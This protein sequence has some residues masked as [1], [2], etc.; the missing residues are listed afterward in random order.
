MLRT[1]VLEVVLRNTTENRFGSK[2][3]D[4]TLLIIYKAFIQ[5]SENISCQADD[6][7]AVFGRQKRGNNF[8]MWLQGCV[9][10]RYSLHGRSIRPADRL[11]DQKRHKI[12]FLKWCH[13]L[14][15]LWQ[16]TNQGKLLH[17]IHVF[18]LFSTSTLYNR[19][20]LLLEADLNVLL[21]MLMGTAQSYVYYTKET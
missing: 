17:I 3:T 1:N 18:L 21:R 9:A 12:Q 6:Y 15:D 11:V 2:N 5:P 20:M 10:R 19:V 13:K 8:V 4:T 7:T 16:K 14:Y